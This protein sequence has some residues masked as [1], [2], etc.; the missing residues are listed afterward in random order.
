MRTVVNKFPRLP[1]QVN[2]GDEVAM[3]RYEELLCLGEGKE[4]EKIMGG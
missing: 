1:E 4:V 3:S 2:V